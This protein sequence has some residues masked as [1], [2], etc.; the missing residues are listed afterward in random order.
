MAQKLVIVGGGFAGLWGAASAARARALF[1]LPD[2]AIDI[3]LVAPD[4]FHTVRVRCYEADLPAI[5]VPLDEVLAPIGVARIEDRVTGIDP[6]ARTLSRAGGPALPYDRLLLAAGSAL[7]VP[8]IPC[9]EPTFDVDTYDGARR[10][11]AHLGGLAGQATPAACTAVV[12]GGGLVGIEIA[13]ELPARLPAPARVVLVDHG[14]IGAAMGAGRPAVVAALAALGV[15]T[16]PNAQVEAVD[17]TGVRLRGGEHIPATTV[18]FATGMKASPLTAGLG[19]ARDRF[20]R[21]MVDAY[22]AVEDVP[23]VYAAGDCASV[24]AD[25]A[26]H[27]SVMSCQHGRP[28]GRLAGHNALCDLAGR[29]QDRVAFDA[30]DYVTV[31]DLG[32][33][34]AVYTSGWDRA[35]LVAT[36]AEAKTVKE[37]I[38]RARIYPPRPATREAI[39]AAAAP[40]IQARPAAD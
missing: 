26:G 30:P 17:A 35:T 18:V 28:M 8:D 16:R 29:P 9:A 14:E 11:A 33:E 38:N 5:R 21:V 25:G 32:P 24:A 22:L 12:I 31:T 19:G 7:A 13:C 40:V 1:A 3:T 15:E 2:E 23:G 6:C 4:A 37:T 36:G 39:F 27:R 20:G 34:G 10:L